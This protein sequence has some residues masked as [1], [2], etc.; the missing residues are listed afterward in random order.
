MKMH[1]SRN[2]PAAEGNIIAP[3]RLKPVFKDYLW[4]GTLLKHAYGKH[5]DLPIL[6]ESWELS[7]HKDGSNVILDGL[8]SGMHFDEFVHLHPL[9]CGAHCKGGSFP[10]LIKLINSAQPLSIQVHPDDPYALKNEGEFGKTEMWVILDSEPGAFVY[11]GFQEE[12]TKHAF[13]AHIK[14][15]TLPDVLRKIPAA[16]GDVLFVP[17]GTIHAIGAG[18]TL[19]EIQQNSNSTYRVYDFGRLGSDGQPRPLHVEKA[20]DVTRLCKASPVAP[21]AGFD[22]KEEGFTFE[23]LARCAVFT[24]KRLTLRKHCVL[25]MSENSFCHALCTQGKISL[26]TPAGGLDLSKGDGAF[27]PAGSYSIHAKGDGTLLLSCV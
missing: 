22:A 25:P 27:F 6:A 3:F 9:V 17:S 14:N 1:P 8:Y 21:G 12:I 24:V 20:L 18:I 23:T 5:S 13:A 15:G 2:T 11:L 19:A 16:R 4:G 26:H 7:A 10:L